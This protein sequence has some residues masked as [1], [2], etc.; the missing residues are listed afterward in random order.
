MQSIVRIQHIAHWCGRHN[1]R[2]IA[3][4]IELLIRLTFAA[5]IPAAASI[6]G[7]VVFY[8]NALA[9]VLNEKSSLGRGCQIGTY[10]VMGGSGK[11]IGAPI[12]EDDVIVHSGAKLIG[13]I[14]IARGSVIG[15]NAVVLS[16]VPERCLMLG[17]PAEIKK[18]N[19]NSADYRLL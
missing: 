7:T 16:D 8:H 3:R 4:S 5:R 10:V 13:A 14:R 19:I 11:S 1:L 15:A 18:S 2:P 17:I 12:L 9:V 6:D